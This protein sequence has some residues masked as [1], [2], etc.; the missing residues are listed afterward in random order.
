MTQLCYNKC[1]NKKHFLDTVLELNNITLTDL[2][3]K[4]QYKFYI[5]EFAE[6]MNHENILVICDSDCDGLSSGRIWR[7]YRPNDTIV[8]LDR[9][10]R[11]PYV[12]A[13]LYPNK[14][15]VCLDCGS[16][17]DW[18]ELSDGTIY[19]IDHHE[20]QIT[21]VGVNYINPVMDFGETTYC[22]ATLLYSLFSSLLGENKTALQYAAI[23]GVADMMPLLGDNRKIVI[24]GLTAMNGDDK[25]DI[26]QELDAYDINDEV[27][28]GF[29]I[30]PSI[31]APSRIGTPELAFDAIVG[32][33]RASIKKLKSANSKRKTLVDKY[34]TEAKTIQREKCW[35]YIIDAPNFA[36]HG[37]IANKAASRYNTSVMCING[38]G[39]SFRSRQNVDFDL[40]IE[41]NKDILS[42]GGHKQAAG[43]SIL[44]S[45][46]ELI[47]RFIAFCNSYPLEE[48]DEYDVLVDG[49]DIIKLR[50]YYQEYKPYGMGFRQPV[51]GAY[52]TVYQIGKDLKQKS[53]DSGYAEIRLKSDKYVYYCV[54]YAVNKE[55]EVGEQ[56]FFHFEFINNRLNIKWIE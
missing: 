2:A 26:V 8:P 44:G 34:Y 28:I 53:V 5:K 21:V 48:K 25:C 20:S 6:L 9:N 39:V 50:K 16:S 41:N 18:T 15:I 13:T 38:N 54:N 30:A 19:V 33:D 43:A 42:G 45:Q 1:M 14:T 7:E 32:A 49:D 56:H 11:N 36:I 4:N 10:N 47:E 27:H 17:V 23:A 31:N 40:F 24:D 22:T 37:L 52:L 35:I 3:S 55:I 46:E 12:I 29:T 51:L